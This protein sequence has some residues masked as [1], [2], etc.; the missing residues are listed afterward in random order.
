MKIGL[1]STESVT[2]RPWFHLV[3]LSLSLCLALA[4]IWCFSIE[5]G[6]RNNLQGETG[7]C[8]ERTS[9]ESRGFWNDWITAALAGENR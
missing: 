9:C 7:N 2:L 3:Q 5:W 1:G 6:K 8:F 4:A